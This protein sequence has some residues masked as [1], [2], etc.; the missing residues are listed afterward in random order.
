MDNMLASFIQVRGYDP[1]VPFEEQTL[2]LT[3]AV[4]ADASCASAECGAVVQIQP[5]AATAS[6]HS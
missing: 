4:P 1:D 3:G 2:N 5:K 6:E